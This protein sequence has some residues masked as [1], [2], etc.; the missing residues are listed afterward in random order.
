MHCHHDMKVKGYGKVM[1]K[2][3]HRVKECE[4]LDMYE[5]QDVMERWTWEAEN[6]KEYLADDG[7]VE[8]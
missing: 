4:W 6:M 5:Q 3:H 7:L 1:W 2:G 8:Q